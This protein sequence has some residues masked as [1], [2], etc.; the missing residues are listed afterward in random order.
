M[1]AKKDLEPVTAGDNPPD[2]ELTKLNR[3]AA[4][5]AV[6]AELA[7]TKAAADDADAD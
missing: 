3:D 4:A 6:A 7:A 5:A 2:D 1:T